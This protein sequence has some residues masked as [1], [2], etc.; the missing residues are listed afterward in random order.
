MTTPTYGIADENGN[1]YTVGLQGEVVARRTAQRI[2]DKHGKTVYLYEMGGEGEPEEI[3]PTTTT[4]LTAATI[5][6]AQIR[7]LRNRA[8]RDSDYQTVDSCD[9]A[10]AAHETTDASGAPLVDSDGE[11]TTRTAQRDLLA[12]VLNERAANEDDERCADHPAVL[13]ARS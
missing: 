4:K 10:M 5:T 1:D 3:E 11:A 12:D 13:A 2:A 9:V 8:L 6:E 7:Q